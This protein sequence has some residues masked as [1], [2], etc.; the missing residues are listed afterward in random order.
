MA[1]QGCKSVCWCISDSQGGSEDLEKEKGHAG[2]TQRAYRVHA[3]LVLPPV[4][5]H[6]SF[7]VFVVASSYIV[8][9]YCLNL[10]FF[11]PAVLVLFSS[12]FS[13]N[14]LL[15]CVLLLPLLLLLKRGRRKEQRGRWI[16]QM[17]N[18]HGGTVTRCIENLGWHVL[19][20]VP[21]S[22]IPLFW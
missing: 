1:H 2:I 16:Q 17:G 4:H 6:S 20:R 10:P 8:W 3:Q 11:Y 15:F 12:L 5:D 19:P 21:S 22:Y 9:W 13:F 14:H 18:G 7:I